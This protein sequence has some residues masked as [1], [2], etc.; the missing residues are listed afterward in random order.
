MLLVRPSRLKLGIPLPFD[1]VIP[2]SDQF[3]GA[4][5][6]ILKPLKVILLCSFLITFKL[7]DLFLPCLITLGNRLSLPLFD[8]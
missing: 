5:S 2:L 7:I 8:E 4:I 6:R 3:V 1:S